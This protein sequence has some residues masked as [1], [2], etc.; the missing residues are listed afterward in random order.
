M[1]DLPSHRELLPR[2]IPHRA[3]WG[4]SPPPGVTPEVPGPGQESVWDYPRPPEVRPVQDRIRV[5]HRGEV[6]ADSTSALRIVETAGAPVYYVPP[7]DID[8]ERLEPAEGVSICEWKGAAVYYNL[9]VGNERIP[10]AAFAYPDPLTDLGQGYD[11]IA[12]WIGFY[13][14]RV[15]EVWVGDERARPQPGGVYAGWVTDAIVGPIKGG[16]GTS[17]W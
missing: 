6:I 14:G 11:R 15:D 9:L 13:V 17:H 7:A 1:A 8:M 10:R 3:H 12:G 5:V 4:P 2:L 16:P